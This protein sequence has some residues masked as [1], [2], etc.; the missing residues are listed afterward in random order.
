MLELLASAAILGVVAGTAVSV[1]RLDSLGNHGA[2]TVARTLA[3][4]LELARSCA[5]SSGD[6]HFL[7]LTGGSTISAYTLHRDTGGSSTVVDAAR[8]ISKQVTVT[9][10]SA[11]SQTPS[12][13]FEGQATSTFSFSVS[14][15]DRVFQVSVTAATGRAIVSEL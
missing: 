15:P 14:G 11:A 5:I 10:S 3:T 12:L 1:M 4:D 2:L 13:T 7:L 8:E 9:I 6:D